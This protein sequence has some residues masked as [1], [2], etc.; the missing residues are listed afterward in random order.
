[1][2]KCPLKLHG[3]ALEGTVDVISMDPP[4]IDNDTP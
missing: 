1:M 4:F 3:F 2:K